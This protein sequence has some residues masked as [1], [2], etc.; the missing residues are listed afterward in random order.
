MRSSKKTKTKTPTLAQ[1]EEDERKARDQ[2]A[3]RLSDPDGLMGELPDD[4]RDI[5]AY[6][7]RDL[8]LDLENETTEWVKAYNAL[9]KAKGKPELGYF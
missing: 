1:L 9:M 8:G 5:E 2:L 6:A 4:P 7:I 3:Y